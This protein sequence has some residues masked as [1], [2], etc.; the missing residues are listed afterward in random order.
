MFLQ[1]IALIGSVFILVAYFQL[2]RGRLAR[3]SQLF[4]AMNFIGSCLLTWT[5]VADRPYGVIFLQG[6]GAPLSLPRPPRPPG[7]Q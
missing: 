1:G 7:P 5:A 4:N 6:A 2:Q 3:E